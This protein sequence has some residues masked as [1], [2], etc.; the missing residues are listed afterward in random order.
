MLAEAE[1]KR[2]SDYFEL[3]YREWYQHRARY[4]RLVV[5]IAIA[6][7]LLSVLAF[8]LLHAKSLIPWGLAG[9]AAIEL[10]DG[11]THK[12]FW[13]RARRNEAFSQDMSVRFTD[14]GVEFNTD[15]YHGAIGYVDFLGFYKTPNGLFL[16]P[17]KGASIFVPLAAISPQDALMEIQQRFK[18]GLK[19]SNR[20][21]PVTS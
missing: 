8:C 18:V 1:I 12:F 7:S 11:L 20:I 2:D 5:P 4:R 16:C 17:I 13:M 9:I 10:V 21:Q 3:Y 6:F 19:D 15:K 14:L